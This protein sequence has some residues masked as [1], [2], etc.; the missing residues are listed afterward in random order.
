MHSARHITS[1][2]VMFIG[3]G[4]QGGGGGAMGHKIMTGEGGSYYS[5]KKE[6]FID[7]IK[8]VIIF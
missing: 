3:L 2:G 8:R 4:E 6:N 7:I 5:L 1:W